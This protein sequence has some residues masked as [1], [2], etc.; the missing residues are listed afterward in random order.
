MRDDPRPFY[1]PD[2]NVFTDT[3]RQRT[4]GEHVW[5]LRKGL[6]QYR[7]EL[8]DRGA[9]GTETQMFRNGGFSY[10]HRFDSRALALHFAATE[11]LALEQDGWMGA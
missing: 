4:P 3:P 10:G 2:R 11:R 1:A 6:D 7:C 8:R 9:W 5:T